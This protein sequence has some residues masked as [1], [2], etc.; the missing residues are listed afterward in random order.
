G[1][2]LLGQLAVQIAHAAGCRVFGVDLSPERVAMAKRLGADD[3]CVRDGAESLGLAFTKGVGF[4]T[5]LL[6]AE[7]KTNDPI[8][9]AAA[10]AR[11]RAH[12]VAV[13]AFDLQ[14]PRKPYFGKELHVQVS[15]SYGPGRY[16]PEYELHG[17]DYPIG[18]VRWTQQRNLD[19]FVQL[20]HDGRLD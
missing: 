6:T 1:L 18:Y 2:G 13:G 7:A 9:L 20:L 17:R 12:V 10:I 5:I 4:D 3:A 11:D 15:R 8:E 14:L 16:D 19:A